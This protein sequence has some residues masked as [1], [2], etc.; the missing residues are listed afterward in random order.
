MQGT[1]SSRK[2]QDFAGTW[3]IPKRGC[4]PVTDYLVLAAGCAAKF[5]L[6]TFPSAL[7]LP[8]SRGERTDLP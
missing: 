5:I 7:P 2:D 1:P 6:I 8:W 4:L 3:V